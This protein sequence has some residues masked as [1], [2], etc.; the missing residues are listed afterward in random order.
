MNR[1]F[2]NILKIFGIFVIFQILQIIN[3]NIA[4]GVSNVDRI[5]GINPT[6]TSIEASKYLY[7]NSYNVIIASSED[8]AD[9]LCS[10]PLS[11]KINAPILLVNN[12][13]LNLSVENEIK[14]LEA[15]KIIII[16]GKG[17]ISERIE[18]NLKKLG[19][20]VR[21][22]GEDR[23]DT[24]LNIAKYMGYSKNIILTT[25]N[26]YADSLSIGPLAGQAD[27]PIILTK[28]DELSTQTV[29]Y[30]KNSI[31][32]KI[33]IIG[34]EGVISNKIQGRLPMAERIAGKDRYETNISIIERFYQSFNFNKVC[35]V[36]DNDINNV[37]IASMIAA[38]TCSPMIL[39]NENFQHINNVLSEKI[40]PST[41]FILFGN[42]SI[43]STDIINNISMKYAT[44]DA[45]SKEYGKD[46]VKESNV[47][48][49]AD[50]IILKETKIDGNLYIEGG[51][52]SLNSTK[53]KGNVLCNLDNKQSFSINKSKLY[54]LKMQQA[55]NN[56]INFKDSEAI[57][58]FIEG[59]E[60]NGFVDLIGS[61]N[62]RV[63]STIVKGN[64]KLENVKGDFG[65][66]TIL[67]EGTKSKVIELKGD[68]N[69]PIYVQGNTTIKIDSNAK[70]SK[71]R[72][73]PSNEKTN[74][75]IQGNVDIITFINPCSVEL[76]AKSSV[77]K[78]EAVL[79][80]HGTIDASEN[81][82]INQITDNI[83]VITNKIMPYVITQ[84][85]A[86]PSDRL[87]D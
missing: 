14:R 26:S 39:V 27:M 24:S 48:I 37:L 85:K 6:E 74:V 11:R 12:N 16:G 57:N 47:L 72:L 84:P 66:I 15:R 55:N 82:N 20:V 58:V 2:Q 25:G 50:G 54:N 61:D 52:A 8:Y 40:C 4:L 69:K 81:S 60:Q 23:Y 29:D 10:I 44:L 34:G 76:L 65:N 73:V 28:K 3:V 43:F 68:Y 17:I 35:L 49:K 42:E 70:V 1:N 71:L 45:K 51:N 83:K 86:L 46:D 33:F 67:N 59:T 32:S 21:I 62:F 63:V 41:K 19:E 36:P 78:V 87:K 13:E 7:R 75:K 22:F 38:N 80:V 9:G 79:G 31:P 5:Y 53:V 30:I 56:I 64:A 18:N 77:K